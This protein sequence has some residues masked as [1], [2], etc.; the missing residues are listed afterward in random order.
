MNKIIYKPIDHAI[1][2]KVTEFLEELDATDEVA[3]EAFANA[4][5]LLEGY[6]ADLVE[7]VTKLHVKRIEEMCRSIYI[8]DTPENIPTNCGITSITPEALS[9]GLMSDEP[10]IY[11]LY[12]QQ[13][14]GVSADEAR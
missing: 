1:A 5:D 3:A 13:K 14:G 6:I 11:S 7:E 8:T 10:L 4:G 9:T 12:G 2:G